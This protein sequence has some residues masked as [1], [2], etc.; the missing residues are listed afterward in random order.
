MTLVAHSVKILRPGTVVGVVALALVAGTAT[1]LVNGRPSGQSLATREISPSPEIATEAPEASA[2]PTGAPSALP[3]PSPSAAPAVSVGPSTSPAARPAPPLPRTTG[4]PA[5]SSAAPVVQTGDWTYAKNGVTLTMRMRPA[6]PRAG[7]LVTY[8]FTASGRD[9]C[10]HVDVLW[11]DNQGAPEAQDACVRANGDGH[12]RGGATYTYQHAY[13]R[14]GTYT[15]WVHVMGDCEDGPLWFTFKPTY[16]VTD[17]PLLSNGPWVPLIGL[18]DSVPA[19]AAE[20]DDGQWFVGDVFDH[21]GFPLEWSWSWGDGTESPVTRNPNACH[22]PK[23][24]GWIES[25]GD[26]RAAHRFPATGT[27]TVTLTA[28]T[29]GCDGKDTQVVSRSFEWTVEPGSAG[30]PV[31]G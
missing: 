26:P 23:D 7:E 9:D 15:P 31:E 28:V 5:P 13:R 10:C 3:A 25:R 30:A 27:Y 20:E 4:S 1:A 18:D 19:S 16:R 11:G 24:G 14:A 12:A 8:T 22:W 17:G 29:G 21:D 6:R 2:S